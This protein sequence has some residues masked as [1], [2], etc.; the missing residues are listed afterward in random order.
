MIAYIALN[1]ITLTWVLTS[2]AAFCL[3][4][5]HISK[6]YGDLCAVR[7]AKAGPAA[8]NVIAAS[9]IAEVMRLVVHATFVML[10]LVTMFVREETLRAHHIWLQVLTWTFLLIPAWV[11]LNTAIAIIMRKRLERIIAAERAEAP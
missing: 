6:T 9:M 3:A 8:A 11:A 1:R 7:E 2:S 4:V 10:G 5:W